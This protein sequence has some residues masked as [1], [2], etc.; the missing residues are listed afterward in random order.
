MKKTAGI[1]AEYNPLHRGHQYHIQETRRITGA[2][3]VIA[4][5]SGDYV[6]RGTPAIFDKY[7]RTKMAL[8][9]GADMVV[10]L[11][12][13]YAT[14]SAESFALGSVTILDALGI[15]TDLCFG[16]ESGDSNL[17]LLASKLLSQEPELY[18]QNLSM[19][20]R[21]GLSFPAARQEAL[22]NFLEKDSE[23]S[24]SEEDRLQLTGFLKKPNN[25]LGIEYCKALEHIHSPIR[26][27]TIVRKGD[28]YHQKQLSKAASPYSSAS[29]LRRCILEQRELS[30]L[31]R[32]IPKEC[33]D[34]FGKALDSPVEAQDFSLLVHMRLLQENAATLPEYLDV[35]QD[36]AN[37]IQNL[38]NQYQSFP[39]FVRLLK[40][41]ELTYTRIQRALLHILLGIKKTPP[42][43]YIRILGVRKESRQLLSSLQEHCRLP[44]AVTPA[45]ALK[46]LP[47]GCQEDLNFQIYVS[48]LY[49]SVRCKK[50]Q[51]TF[52]PEPS[53]P[54]LVL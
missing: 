2:D 46:S 17:F 23:S 11:P 30:I 35:S 20:L 48:D 31:S 38:K 43:S 49:E 4:V 15:V 54:L 39:Q 22:L 50:N 18:R 51:S 42:I 25:I 53:R 21:K 34:L 16:S 3:Q 14:A 45:K 44:M 6:Q 28:G 12:V 24:F 52:C 40:T 36:L 8:L 27:H 26:P 13:E 19:H 33:E 5:I 47:A 29:A 1:I 7:E 10:E 32:H 41:R 37:R 9:C